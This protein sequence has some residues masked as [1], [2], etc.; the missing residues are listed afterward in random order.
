MSGTLNNGY[1]NGDGNSGGSV[2]LHPLVKKASSSTVVIE[3]YG[4]SITNIPLTT[5]TSVKVNKCWDHP[6][7]DDS[8]F[9]REQ[10]TIRLYANGVDTGR[11][12]TVNL[13]NDWTAVFYGLPYLDDA[14]V[15]IV[16]TVVEAWDS[17]DWIPIYGQVTTTQ[18]K[19]PTYEV[20]ITNRYRWLDACELPSTGGIGVPIYI[21]FGLIL[22]IGPFVYGFRLRCRNGRRSK[23]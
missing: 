16:Y 6:L 15:P 21:L 10:I 23:N 5:E 18:G 19:V 4:Y 13:K 3:G 2:I 12:E 20:T 22:V 14:G 1:L 11:T 9:E 17:I 7:S 8:I